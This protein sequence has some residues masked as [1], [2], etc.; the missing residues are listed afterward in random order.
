MDIISSPATLSGAPFGGVNET[1]PH[2]GMSPFISFNTYKIILIVISY[3][4]TLGVAGFGVFSNTANV[5]VYIKMG[6]RETTNIS[7]FALAII[8]WLVSTI[9]F[10]YVGSS[11]SD[12]APIGQEMLFL[13]QRYLPAI[14]LP[15]LAC[16]AWITAVLSAERCLCIVMPLKVGKGISVK[17]CLCIAMPLK[18]GK[19]ISVESC[20][21]IAMPLKVGKAMPVERCLSTVM[22]LKVS[23]G[24]FTHR[25]MSL[26]SSALEGG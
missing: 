17:S 19:G 22:P 21:C 10:P 1:H 3:V 16:G 4:L 2:S 15:C 13:S 18:V 9:S 7:F 6:L 20:F 24:I 14:M 12:I 11:I 26:Y 8:D 25:E 5:V 23:K